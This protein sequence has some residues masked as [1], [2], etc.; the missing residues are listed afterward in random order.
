MRLF[1]KLIIGFLLLILSA[2]S[3]LP[4]GSRAQ[5][6]DVKIETKYDGAKDT[7]TVGFEELMVSNTATEKLILSVEGSYSG[8]TA[9]KKHPDDV[10]LILSCLNRNGYKYPKAMVLLITADGKQL[11]SVLMLNFDR[12]RLDEDYLETLGTRMKYDTFFATAQA[13]KVEMKLNDTVFSLN[14]QHIKKLHD[15]EDL[16]HSK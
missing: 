14:E 2:Q 13:K 8:K 5:G 16:L 15:L 12:Q 3:I 10:V 6:S 9:P 7:T 1:A 4:A 11:P